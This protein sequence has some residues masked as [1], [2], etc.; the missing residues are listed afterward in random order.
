MKEEPG[1]LNKYERKRLCPGSQKNMK[2]GRNQ[3]NNAEEEVRIW[4]L[5]SYARYVKGDR[6]K[7]V[8]KNDDGEH[9]GKE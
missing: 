1:I 4:A 8:V 3:D 6:S 7:F 9:Y 5:L 2:K